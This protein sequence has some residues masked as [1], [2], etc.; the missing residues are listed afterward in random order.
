MSSPVHLSHLSPDDLED[1]KQFALRHPIKKKRVNSISLDCSRYG[2]GK[3][4]EALQDHLAHA[5]LAHFEKKHRVKSVQRSMGVVLANLALAKT[6]NSFMWVRHSRDPKVYTETGV[7]FR[8]MMTVIDYLRHKGLVEYKPGVLHLDSGKSFRSIMRGTPRLQELFDDFSISGWDVCCES[9]G[10]LVLQ[11]KRG[12]RNIKFRPTRQTRGVEAN[13][14]TINDM[15][16]THDIRLDLPLGEMFPGEYVNGK[17]RV[18][19]VSKVKL[20]RV[21]N[22]GSFAF[23]GRFFGHWIQSIPKE[24]RPY[25]SIDGEPTVEID[26]VSMQIGML[27]AREG[28]TPPDGDLYALPGHDRGLCK[29]ALNTLL[30][31][32]SVKS[33]K[34]AVALCAHEKGLECEA[35]EAG[36]IVEKLMVKHEAVA[37]FFASDVGVRLMALE[38]AVAEDVMLAFAEKGRVCLPV[39]D[40]FVCQAKYAGELDAQ[41]RESYAKIVGGKAKTDLKFAV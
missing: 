34:Q 2:V 31:A 4:W 40:S 6:S 22:R 19:D 39:H 16:L 35:G 20:Y 11:G 23:G 33:A 10:P 24:Y 14:E 29:I 9:K 13:L 18:C 27:Y 26:F 36:Q 15:I 41:M 7:S 5:A 30:N 28:L 32:K 12:S 3:Q 1:L 38:S 21:F 8:T 17:L 37:S 25:V